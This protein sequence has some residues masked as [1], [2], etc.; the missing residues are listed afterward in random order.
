[1]QPARRRPGG[2]SDRRGLEPA[3]R[4][5]LQRRHPAPPPRRDRQ[6]ARVGRGAGLRRDRRSEYARLAMTSPVDSTTEQEPGGDERRTRLAG[7]R[8][9]WAPE[10]TLLAW[11]RTGMAA[12]AVALAVGRLLPVL[13][14]NATRWPYVVL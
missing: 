6:G 7:E 10:R 1:R 8:P 2:D 13:A 11:W 3:L 4:G 14:P 12:L 9:T 5:R